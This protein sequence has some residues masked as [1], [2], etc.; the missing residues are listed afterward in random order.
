[1]RRVGSYC[2]F[3]ALLL[4][5][6]CADH[7]TLA[8]S[9]GQLRGEIQNRYGQPVPRLLITLLRRSSVPVLPVLTRTNNEGKIFLENME[10]G[11][12][13]LQVKSTRYHSSQT[14]NI[15]IR[16][17]QTAIFTLVLQQ[18]LG[19]GD[20][21]DANLSVKSLLRTSL[22]RRLI[23]RGLPG[24]IEDPPRGER[25][26]YPFQNAV[27]QVY[28]KAGLGGDYLVFPGSSSSGT[29]TNFALSDSLGVNSD[30]IFAGQL[31]SGE[32]SMWRL[33]NF[34]NYD[35]G[36]HHSLR[37]FLGYGRMS[38]DQPGWA[39]MGNPSAMESNSDFLSAVGTV[40]TMSAGFQDTLQWGDC[41]ALV[42]GLEWNQVR[43]GYSNSF[44]SPSAELSYSPIRGT[45]ISALVAS[46]RS[47]HGNTLMLPQ[48]DIVNLSDAVYFSQLGDQFGLG[49]ARYYRGSVTRRLNETTE[50]ELAAYRNQFFGTTAPFLAIFQ[51]GPGMKAFQLD[52][53]QA[54]NRGYRVSI[55]RS[56]GENVKTAV[57][58]IRADA[59]GAEGD[60]LT[61]FLGESAVRGWIRRQN[62]HGF[63]T[64]VQA[65]IPQSQTRFT[66]L[67]KLVPEGNPL[68]ALDTFA[69]TYETYNKGVNLFV[70][71]IVPLPSALLGLLGLD[72][73]STYQVEALL[74]VRNLMNE[75][76]GL[77]HTASGDVVLT[78][79]PRTLRGGLSFQF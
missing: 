17:G 31:N 43:S 48:G 66:V 67:V 45:K 61:F 44:T 46:K 56:F 47:T 54:S 65:S 41:L 4:L 21:T 18:L 76:L 78:H 29:T 8:S 53:S 26:N 71:Q 35:L 7:F 62:Y 14:P 10:V 58:Y 24:V 25:S 50:L 73:L 51:Q 23:L 38:F 64:Q 33:K 55:N 34:V 11:D 30:Y 68:T 49:T 2:F 74:D 22:D 72:F 39:L 16:T 57:S 40:K 77:I 9:Y 5:F 28:N 12:Y 32:D 79:N 69:D 27:F 70:R 15:E 3:S 42:W 52:G 13:E 75:D 63:S 1:M 37:L 60:H 19:L 6:L 59:V 36:E 20:S